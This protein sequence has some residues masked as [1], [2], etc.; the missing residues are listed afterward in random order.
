MTDKT[1]DKLRY[2]VE[3]HGPGGVDIVKVTAG[4]GDEAAEKAWKPGTVIRGI[5]PD[6][7]PEEDALMHEA[8]EKARE[9]QQAQEPDPKAEAAA[10]RL[11]K[12]ADKATHV[13]RKT[14]PYV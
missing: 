7:E 8:E 1:T 5:V 3:R 6:E 14:P 2:K 11:A 4:S 13:D 12:K 9:T 10:E